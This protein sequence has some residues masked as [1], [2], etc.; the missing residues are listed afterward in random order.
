MEVL[1]RVVIRKVS[2]QYLE[3]GLVEVVPWGTDVI[4]VSLI[5]GGY[6]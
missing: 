4:S 6:C 1:Q 2:R 5:P 3:L